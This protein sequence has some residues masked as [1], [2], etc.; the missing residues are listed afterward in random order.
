MAICGTPLVLFGHQWFLRVSLPVNFPHA[1]I[2]DEA[3]VRDLK[4][5]MKKKAAQTATHDSISK[6]IQ[7]PKVQYKSFFCLCCVI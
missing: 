5:K 2:Y 1:E 6:P 7:R 4:E 3:N